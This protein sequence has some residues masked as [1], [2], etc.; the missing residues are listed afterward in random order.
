MPKLPGP[1]PKGPG[2]AKP[3]KTLPKPK[4]PKGK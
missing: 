1:H 3:P 2:G 4:T